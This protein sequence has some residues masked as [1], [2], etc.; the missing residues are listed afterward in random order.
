MG[1]FTK[2]AVLAFRNDNGLPVVDYIDMTMLVSLMR[3]K[4]RA[5]PQQAG[6]PWQ[7]EEETLLLRRFDAGE[8][9]AAIA[10]EHGRTTGGIR[11]RL[12]YLGKL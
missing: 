10:R 11:S 12:K 4:P 1:L 9:V 7:A 5:L 6:K 8:S 2:A 3:A